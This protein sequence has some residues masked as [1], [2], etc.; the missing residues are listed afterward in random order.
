MNPL[1]GYLVSQ[2]FA[3]LIVFTRMGGALT[4][5]PGFG[6]NYVSIRWRLILALAISLLMAPFLEQYLPPIPPDPARLLFLLTGELFIGVFVGLVARFL[7][8][9][10][11][12]A[13]MVISYQSSLALATQF[14]A[15]QAGQ[16]SIIG[17]LLAISALM[18]IFALDLHH[19]LL[20]GVADSYTLM[21]PGVFPPMEDMFNYL[22]SLT[23]HIFRV[24]VQFAAPSIVVGLLVY[25]SAGILG[26]LMPN[27]QVFFVMMPLQL[28]VGFFILMAVFHSI[29]TAF[30]QYF[31]ETYSNFLQGV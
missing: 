6:E 27:M 21:E 4:M 11:H 29:M 2:L 20:R 13:G 23:S 18:L 24:G 31:A 12:V 9:A 15:T 16:G 19:M 17:N 30:A 1:E 28:L 26:R 7:V 5:L 14:D 25:L 8:A 3:I 10:M 22:A